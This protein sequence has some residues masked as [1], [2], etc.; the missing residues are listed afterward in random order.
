MV[1]FLRRISTRGWILIFAILSTSVRAYL[2]FNYRTF[3]NDD[4]AYFVL[5]DNLL[6]QGFYS[7]DGDTYHYHYPPMFPVF[8][9]GLKLFNLSNELIKFV[10][11]VLLVNLISILILKI[12]CALKKRITF[13]YVSIAFLNPIFIIGNMT[14]DL[15]VEILYSIFVLLGLLFLINS[16]MNDSLIAWRLSIVFICFAFLTREE[17]ALFLLWH[18]LI[19]LTKKWKT[20]DSKNYLL[21]FC[22]LTIPTVLF[23]SIYVSTQ[24]GSFAVSG[25]LLPN[26]GF[27]SRWGDLDIFQGIAD[28]LITLLFSPLF[29]SPII[30]LMFLMFLVRNMNSFC[31]EKSRGLFTQGLLFPIYIFVTPFFFLIILFAITNPL[32]RAMYILN[33][34]ILI[35]LFYLHQIAS[36]NVS[37]RVYKLESLA[38]SS[39]PLFMSMTLLMVFASNRIDTSASDYVKAAHQIL[40]YE[41]LKTKESIKIYSR[42][43]SLSLIDSKIKICNSDR[44]CTTPQYYILS[45]SRH[46]SLLN[47]PVSEL[48]AV[49]ERAEEYKTCNLVETWSSKHGVTMLYKC[50][51]E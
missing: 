14:L 9:A 6:S 46:V 7:S 25:K 21:S 12:L 36:D 37:K 11:N 10:N 47:M 26:E 16:Y 30:T 34:L 32:A 19:W 5:A 23:W 31:R 24:T 8:I 45:N 50:P 28:S 1:R 4:L 48:N 18:I 38:F 49:N 20:Q 27:S 29:T 17:G 22:Q 41:K 3:H 39:I 40:N 15:S 51:M 43:A 44:S 42:A 2:F 13:V 35:L 33:C